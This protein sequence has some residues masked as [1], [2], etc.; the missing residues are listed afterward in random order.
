MGW[1]LPVLVVAMGFAAAYFGWRVLTRVWRREADW[2]DYATLDI[3]AV[4]FLA[5]CAVIALAAMGA[6]YGL[7][8]LLG[9][10]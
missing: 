3:V 9:W 1:W 5:G 2:S 10:V 7:L 4:G 8:S 6:A